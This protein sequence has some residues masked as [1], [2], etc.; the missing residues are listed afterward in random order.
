M[1]IPGNNRILSL[2][3]VQ[4]FAMVDG[5]E[6][7][8]ASSSFGSVATQS[9]IY[10]GGFDSIAI[11]GVTSYD[12]TIY[13]VDKLSTFAGLISHTQAEYDPWLKV[14]FGGD[15][16]YDITRVVLFNRL[17]C[18][19]ERLN[20]AKVSVRDYAGYVVKEKA[21]IGDMTGVPSAT[22]IFEPPQKSLLVSIPGN[23]RILSLTEVQAF[24]MVDG[25]ETN[26]ASSSFGSVATQSSIYG[27][28]FDSIAIDGVTSYDVTIYDVDKLSTFAGLISHTQA[29]YDPWLKVTFGGD[30]YYDITRVVLFNRLDCCTERLNK[31]KVSVRDY[32]GYVVKEKALIGDMTGVPSATLIFD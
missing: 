3:E 17:D 10:G 25:I 26:V 15:G 8:V 32:A 20:K 4:A 12:V 7:N 28:G 21:L 9:S 19:T 5:I 27:G 30:G 13:D 1:Y 23:N 22:I 31:A 6:T 16:Y 11:D 14:T 24:A 18:C 29:E 2:T